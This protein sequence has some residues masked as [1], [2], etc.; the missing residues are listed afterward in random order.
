MVSGYRPKY[1]LVILSNIYTGYGYTDHGNIGGCES[2]DKQVDDFQTKEIKIKRK[3]TVSP[4]SE[5][6]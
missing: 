5:L 1:R 3:W 6:Q 2:C 4:T